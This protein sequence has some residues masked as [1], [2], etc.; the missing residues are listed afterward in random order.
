MRFYH[1]FWSK[2]AHTLERCKNFLLKNLHLIALSLHYVKKHGHEIVLHTDSVAARI[3]NHLPY[4]DIYCTLDDSQLK[5]YTSKV[6]W[7]AG[8]VC[9]HVK[10]P[11]GSIS[12]DTDVLLKKPKVF[13]ILQNDK[14]RIALVVQDLEI[15]DCGHYEQPRNFIKPYVMHRYAPKEMRFDDITAFNCGI[16]GF[17]DAGLKDGYISA[18]KEITLLLSRSNQLL[19]KIDP[20]STALDLFLEQMWLKNLT[21]YHGYNVKKLL[22]DRITSRVN[23][24]KDDE[25]G[26]EHFFTDFKEKEKENIK[27]ELLCENP[28]L[29]VKIENLIKKEN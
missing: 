7:A 6:F 10:E 24:I 18:Y 26:Y 1:S 15:D 4:D 22:P 27:R 5:E 14:G 8:K 13:D 11:L 9:A 23:I 28:N 21:D 17:F 2:P 20:K 16:I 29:F 25:L 19:S 3:L 12:I